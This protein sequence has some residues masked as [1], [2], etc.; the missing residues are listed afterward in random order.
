MSTLVHLLRNELIRSLSQ[1]RRHWVEPAVSMA[2]LSGLFLGLYFGIRSVV[3]DTSAGRL[4]GL[5]VGY[6]TWTVAGAGGSSISRN[7][8]EEAQT[9]TLEQLFL[10]PW[11]FHR[12]AICRAMVQMIAGL[13]TAAVLTVVAMLATGRWLRLPVPEVIAVLALGSLAVV[14]VG[15]ALAGSALV[16]K[17]TSSVAPF[18]H[19]GLIAIVSVPAYPWNPL[20]VLPFSYAASLV[21]AIAAGT[22]EVTPATVLAVA[23]SSS[24]YLAAGVAIYLGFEQRALAEGSLSR[25]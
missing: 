25:Y 21:R 9:G 19:I 7:V 11:G 24:V 15:L 10:G 3:T 5:I 12:V 16:Y 20:S 1:L 18:L 22:A 2:I 8:V 14:G 4:D 23:L 17:R 6:M 13:G